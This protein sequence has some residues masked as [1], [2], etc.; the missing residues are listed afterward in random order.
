[1]RSY[2]D[3][4]VSAPPFPFSSL[5][6]TAVLGV[7]LNKWWQDATEKIFTMYYESFLSFTNEN[8][9]LFI[10]YIEDEPS[11]HEVIILSF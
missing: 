5:G 8:L 9:K 2:D 7:G 10:G 3:V 6:V 1:M 11:H 4:H